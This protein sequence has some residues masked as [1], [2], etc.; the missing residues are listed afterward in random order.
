MTTSSPEVLDAIR[1]CERESARRLEA[2]RIESAALIEAARDT[3]DATIDRARRR[4]YDEA[5]ARTESLVASAR[6][7]ASRVE[8]G[9]TERIS[10][11]RTSAHRHRSHIVDAM[12]ALIAPEAMNGEGEV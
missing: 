8:A 9:A 1:R 6:L 11:L 3:A 12:V 4:A 10:Q 2:A 5:S 7:E